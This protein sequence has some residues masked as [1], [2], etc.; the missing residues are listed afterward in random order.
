[1]TIEIC[2]LCLERSH[3][4]GKPSIKKRVNSGQTAFKTQSRGLFLKY[5]EK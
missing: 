3:R 5:G 4:S 2:K 1:M